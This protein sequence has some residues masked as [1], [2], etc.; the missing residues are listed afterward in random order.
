[1]PTETL[2]EFDSAD[3]LQML[4]R[5]TRRSDLHGSMWKLREL[6]E[7]IQAGSISDVDAARLSL[8]T[9][10]VS[11][12]VDLYSQGG[13][14]STQQPRTRSLRNLMPGDD[15]TA[16]GWATEYLAANTAVF[17]QEIADDTFHSPR[18]LAMSYWAEVD[19][20]LHVI[21][22]KI[23]QQKLA[24]AGLPD[25][26]YVLEPVRKRTLIDYSKMKHH[27]EATCLDQLAFPTTLE[28]LEPT[29]F[30][31]L[32]HLSVAALA[33]DGLLNLPMDMDYQR[34]LTG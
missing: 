30:T 19:G 33:D 25:S 17:H 8:V 12:N 31:Q 14:L 29:E 22:Q 10:Y 26:S 2:N 15:P 9:Q 32:A 11:A 34:E 4:G 1:M 16:L 28:D 23:E 13:G 5:Y 6:R 21:E 20:G 3:V 7:Q 27:I 24:L 18:V